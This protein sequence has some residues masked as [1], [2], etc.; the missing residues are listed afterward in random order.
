VTELEAVLEARCVR[1]LEA[2]GGLAL[3]LRPP[4]GR[5]FPDRTCLM[6]DGSVFFLEF[7][8]PKGGVIARQ[9]HAWRMALHLL[10]FGVYFV[11]SDAAFAEAL[12]N[13]GFN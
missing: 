4:T 3:K 13:E 6:P 8:R 11:N 7:K 1:L 9:Q 5:G 10:G 12:R 2:Q